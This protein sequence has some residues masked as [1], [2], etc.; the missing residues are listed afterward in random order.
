MTDFIVY[1]SAQQRMQA[2][3]DDIDP[4][5]PRRSARVPRVE[6]SDANAVRQRISIALFRLAEAIQPVGEQASALGSAPR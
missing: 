6:W 4:S 2:N 3:L 5:P 1:I